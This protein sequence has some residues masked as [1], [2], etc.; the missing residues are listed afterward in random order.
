EGVLDAGVDMIIHCTFWNPDKS[1]TYRPDL[2]DRIVRE[3]RWVNPTLY[4]GMYTEIEGLEARR[5]RE[6]SLSAA[7]ESTLSE[8]RT[9]MDVLLDHTR[10]MVQAGV[11]MIA[12]SDTAWRWGRAGGLAQE[13]YWLGQAG[14]PNA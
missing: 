3:D 6:G 7:D 14:M 12:G 10:R 13:V 11:K 5:A 1:L 2:V 4:G 8:M 9:M